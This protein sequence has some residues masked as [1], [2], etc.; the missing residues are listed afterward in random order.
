MHI[1]MYAHIVYVS[2]MYF[3]NIEF[4]NSFKYLGENN[5]KISY[6][7]CD[8]VELIEKY[9]NHLFLIKFTY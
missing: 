6:I 5:F 7:L 4:H 2:K 3:K 9:G 8:S 1:H